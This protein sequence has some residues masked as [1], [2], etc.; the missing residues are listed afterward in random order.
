MFHEGLDV[1][2][3]Q[4]EYFVFIWY[5]QST[6]WLPRLIAHARR[7]LYQVLRRTYCIACSTFVALPPIHSRVLYAQCSS[8]VN[9]H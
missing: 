1:L 2:G 5:S 9:H 8:K 3:I 6:K 7:L 4:G